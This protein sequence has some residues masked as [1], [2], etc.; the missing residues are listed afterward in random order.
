MRLIYYIIP[1]SIFLFY[2]CANG[3]QKKDKY[4][5]DLAPE[6]IILEAYAKSGGDFWKRPKSLSLK[7]HSY[8]YRDGDTVF[9]QVH[10][11]WRVFENSKTNAH[12]ANGKVRIESYRDSIPA[13]I[14]SYDGMNTY[15]LN[16]KQAK[17]AADK[18]WASNFGFGVI[19]HALDD[20]Y[21]L[22][23]LDGIEVHNDKCYQIKVID[24]NQG[25][26]IFGI[27]KQDYKIVKV[28]FDTPRGWHERLY[29]KFFTKEKYSWLQ[30][31]KVELF[32]E[33]VRSNDVIWTDFEVNEKLDSDLFVLN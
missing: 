13:F 2:A 9:H 25:E 26:T 28:A 10:N 19:R 17:S 30:S 14:V 8:F 22:E 4:S 27:T 33:G 11:M 3:N 29:S 16:G 12:A 32:Y 15:D 24:P 7:G 1:V 21:K 18:R 5:V 23:K 6:E 31:G 20:G